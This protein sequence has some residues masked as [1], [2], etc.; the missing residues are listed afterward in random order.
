MRITRNPALAAAVIILGLIGLAAVFAGAIAPYSPN[1]IDT[2]H[3]LNAPSWRHLAGTDEIGRDL[4]SRIL[5][6]ARPS[7]MVAVTIVAIAICGGIVVGCAS[8]LAGGAVDTLVMRLVEMVMALP[9]LVIA[10]A[11]AAALG[12]SLVN[13]AVALGLLGI[14]Y[15]ARVARAQTL[16]LRQ[17]NYVR[18]ARAM[19]AS[20]WF[21]MRRHIVPNLLPTIVVFGSLG[22]SGALLGPRR[23]RSSGSAR[24][25]R[26]PSGV[27][28]STPRAG[29]C[30]TTGGTRSFQVP[31]WP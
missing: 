18:I 6:G 30:W 29:T 26:W 20:P 16:S 17:R 8:G 9:G 22:L 10:L 13:L 28:W 24:S 12:P 5:Y 7:I 23:C 3:I 25:H 14:P 31:R 4:F 1:A 11:L 27:R 21:I 15:Y 19:G 2:D